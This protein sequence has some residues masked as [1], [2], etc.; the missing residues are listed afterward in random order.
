MAVMGAALRRG[1]NVLARYRLDEKLGEGGMGVVW[2]AS[3]VVTH[4]QVALKILMVSSDENVWRFFREARIAGA[5]RHPRLVDVSDLLRL[6]D[7]TPVMVMEL[8][9]G[10]SLGALL[11]TGKEVDYERLAGALADVADA[12]ADV[13]ARG[14]VH[15]DLKPENVFLEDAGTVKI[16]DFGVAKLSQEQ[17]TDT[18]DGMTQ[19]GSVVGTPA[20]M[21]PEQVFGER[22]VDARADAWALGAILFEVFAGRRLVQGENFGQAFKAITMG[23]LPRVGDLAPKCSPKVAALID[24]MLTRDREARFC[25]FRVVASRLRDLARGVETPEPVEE[26]RRTGP[27]WVLAALVS[28][29][30]LVAVGAYVV[31]LQRPTPPIDIAPGPVPS[32]QPEPRAMQASPAP[33]VVAPKAATA[34]PEAETPS[35]A[36]P[37]AMRI[38]TAPPDKTKAVVPSVPTNSE[39]QRHGGISPQNPYTHP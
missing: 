13:H 26:P 39:E 24:G 16:L 2:S 1:E 17:V 18:I 7:G 35:T 4:K 5:L 31:T 29:L 3:H 23:D 37:D 20:Y 25:D 10:Q 15:R 34:T 32:A 28:A 36:R 14:V 33:E 19:T 27:R 22:D 9:H 21:A 8:L 12:L 30:V 38:R 6:E 11:E